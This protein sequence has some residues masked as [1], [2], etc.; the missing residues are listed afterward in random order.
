MNSS[1]PSGISP[2]KYVDQ[3]SRYINSTV[4][5]YS[6]PI[7]QYITFS[8]YKKQ[9]QTVSSKDTFTVLNKKYEYRP[10]KL[11]NDVYLDSRLWWRIMEAN[12]IKDIFDFKAGINI[13]IPS[14]T[15]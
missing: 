4:E 13:R 14:F 11:A 8:T 2:L 1:Q 3:M 6:T 9:P 15:I 7:T 12:N 5:Y 10:D